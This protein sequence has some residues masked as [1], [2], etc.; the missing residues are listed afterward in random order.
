[1]RT[2]IHPSQV[3]PVTAPS[4]YGNTPE[5]RAYEVE[6]MASV[7]VKD[8]FPNMPD[9]IY[10]KDGDDIEIVEKQTREALE[11]VDMSMIK[12][13]D[14]VN[15][16]CCEHGFLIFGGKP[17]VK[18]LQTIRDVVAERTG[19]HNVTLKLVMFRTPREGTEAIDYYDL[20]NAF[21]NN[22]DYVSEYDKAV[23]IKTRLGTVYGLEKCYNADH[24]ILGYYDD[25][26]EVYMSNY[27]RKSFKCFTMDMARF[28]T[29]GLF[30]F[31]MGQTVGNGPVSNIVPCSIYDSEYV[32]SKWAFACF[33]RTT[34]RGLSM[35]DADNNL[36]TL[37]DRIMTT[38]LKYYPYVYHL[39]CSLPDFNLIIDG[40]R[41]PYYVGIAGVICGCVFDHWQDDYDIDVR[42]S[43]WPEKFM[44]DGLKSVIYNQTW[45]GLDL[46]NLP[47]LL[48]VIMVG[49]EQW[50][51]WRTDPCNKPFTMMPN[52]HKAPDLEDAMR[53]AREYSKNDNFLLADGGYDFINCTPSL[54][55]AMLELAPKIKK[56]VD[57]ELYPKYMKQRGLEIPDFMKD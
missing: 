52:V 42:Y 9:P 43:S 21:D 13:E 3:V 46:M 20:R 48:P 35:I 39:L 49:D 51:L 33:M 57:E 30:H 56:K 55:E 5:K 25:P 54:A 38:A 4:V 17:Y 45:I 31:A 24:I 1:M 10:R 18:M 16:L 26:R 11:K 50:E 7:N 12:P 28:E 29:R 6:G 37:D 53:Q 47:G 41:W 44:A 14:S 15:L 34:P 36:Y 23:P 22:V 32:Q 27:Y 40:N 2:K 8:L 19:N